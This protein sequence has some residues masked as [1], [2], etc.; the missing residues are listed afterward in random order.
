MNESATKDST[1]KVSW[2]KIASVIK[3]R[4]AC[5]PQPAIS[6][7]HEAIL[8]Q[9]PAQLIALMTFLHAELNFDILL[10]INAVEY[11]EAVQMI[12]QLQRLKPEYEMICLKVNLDKNDPKIASVTGLWQ[13]ANWYEREIWDMHGI[14]FEGHP[15]LKRLLNPDHW[16]GFPL[17][18][19]YLPPLDAL[20]GPITAVKANL[21]E[22]SKHT[23]GDVEIIQEPN[24]SISQ[25]IQ[26]PLNQESDSTNSS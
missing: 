19:D 4:F 2:G 12:Y 15:N 23:R 13:S 9:D 20:N 1:L 25:G 21:T 22:L 3:G 6:G 17:R 11:K 16:E 26:E 8:L 18:K 5:I 7:G 14:V 24:Q 10:L